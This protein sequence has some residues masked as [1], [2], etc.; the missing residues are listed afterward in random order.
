MPG[1]PGLDGAVKLPLVKLLLLALVLVLP[2]PLAVAAVSDST[3]PAESN[4][5]VSDLG[6][7]LVWIRPG[8]F[9]LG[10]PTAGD[11]DER[12]VTRVSLTAGFW[13]GVT[14]VTQAQ[15]T[16]VMGKNPSAHRGAGLPVES[17]TWSEA[18]DF[19]RRLTERE[20]AAGRLPPGFAYT[21]PTEAQWE[22]ACRAGTTGDYAGDPGAMAWHG[23]NSGYETHPVG[24]KLPNAWGLYDMHGNVWEW[25]L[26][27]YA[28]YPGGS[29]TDPAGPASGADRVYRGGSWGDVA[30]ASRSSFRNGRGPGFRLGSLGLRVALAPAR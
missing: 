23:A 28:P 2:A 18:R 16:A 12:P 30:G 19:C 9:D 24:A 20:R 25:C 13:L 15:W 17:V 7:E 11:G 26:D 1:L 29:I 4:F 14:E 3:R 5:R 8:T 6:L 27:W 22:Y 21:L 10:S